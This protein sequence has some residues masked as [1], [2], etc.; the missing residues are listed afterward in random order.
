MLG[1]TRL[2]VLKAFV[3]E[4]GILGLATGTVAAVIGGFAAW[5]VIVFLMESD[6]VFLPGATA[7]TLAIGLIVTLAVGFAGT[8]RALGQKAAPY[9]RNE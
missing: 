2:R 3:L 1:A 6:W 5:A 4:Y 7:A 8:W 9:L